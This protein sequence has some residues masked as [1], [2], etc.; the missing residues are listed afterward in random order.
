MS[1]HSCSDLSNV[2]WTEDDGATKVRGLARKRRLWTA[3]QTINIAFIGGSE[4]QRRF[5]RRVASMW[6]PFANLKFNFNAT[7]SESDVRVSFVDG[8][9]SWSFLGTDARGVPKERATMNFGWLPNDPAYRAH[10]GVV[11]HEFG[12]MLNLS[13]EH[14]SPRNDLTWNEAQIIAD[15]ASRSDWSEAKTRGNIINR[16]QMADDLIVS[17]HFDKQSVMSYSF[18]AT[19]NLEGVAVERSSDLS[20]EDKRIIEQ[21][22]PFG[23]NEPI[24]T[25]LQRCWLRVKVHVLSAVG[26]GTCL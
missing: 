1:M 8:D 21:M 17:D 15:M 26:R 16:V 23:D 25:R 7:V 14:Q 18:P 24:K 22:Y 3:G 19:W 13:H 9:G 6:L 5:V 2:C 11:L 12:H 10:R 20:R 4:G